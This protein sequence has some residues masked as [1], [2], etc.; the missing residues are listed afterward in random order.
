MKH[1]NRQSFKSSPYQNPLHKA[2]YGP[3]RGGH[4]FRGPL[5]DTRASDLNHSSSCDHRNRTAPSKSQWVDSRRTYRRDEEEDY[6]Y[7][8]PQKDAAAATS[9]SKVRHVPAATVPAAG[10]AGIDA[11]ISFVLD[12]K[13]GGDRNKAKEDKVVSEVWKW[14]VKEKAKCQPAA[15]PC[16]G[17]YNDEYGSDSD[18]DVDCDWNDYEESLNSIHLRGVTEDGLRFCLEKAAKYWNEP[19]SSRMQIQCPC[20]WV[21]VKVSL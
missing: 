19:D 21:R 9:S 14:V 2:A 15:G 5:R 6:G 1:Y 8:G 11:G 16:R 17:P 3:R 10:D 20:E 7:Y 12:R 4:N 18:S 13:G